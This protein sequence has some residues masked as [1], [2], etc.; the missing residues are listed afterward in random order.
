MN[1]S[2]SKHRLRNVI[3]MKTNN[4]HIIGNLIKRK[5]FGTEN[6]NES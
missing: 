5:E 4:F 3:L 6:F 1:L 2:G